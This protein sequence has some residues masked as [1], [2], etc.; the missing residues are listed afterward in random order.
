ML[1]SNNGRDGLELLRHNTV[2]VI[3]MDLQMPVMGGLPTLEELRKEFPNIPVIILTAFGEVKTAIE[4]M[5]L[6]AYDYLS[7]PMEKDVLIATVHRALENRELRR[8]IELW[9]SRAQKLSEGPLAE[10]KNPSMQ[11]VLEQVRLVSQTDYTVLLTGETGVG[12]DVMAHALHAQS[13]RAGKIF[14]PVDCGAIPE[15]LAESELFGYEKGAFTGADRRKEGLFELADGG[16]IF[17]DELSNLSEGTQA[18]ILRVLQERKIMRVGGK[19]FNDIDVRVIVATNMDLED[20]IKNGRFRED[21]FYRLNEFAITIPPLRD[22]LE[23]FESLADMFM[24]KTAMELGKKVALSSSAIDLMKNHSWPGNVRELRNVLRSA[25]LQCDDEI[26]P[27][28]VERLMRTR[29]PGEEPSGGEV[30]ASVNHIMH[31][32]TS[33]KNLVRDFERKI[34]AEVVRRSDGDNKRA[35]QLLGL[36]YTT[37]LE[38]LR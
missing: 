29:R 1:E 32:Q 27:E 21:L 28:H 2:D 31:G 4:A 5:R 37:L 36:H 8:E 38:K 25:M 16:T 15:N 7:K 6:G 20:E 26:K 33:L 34:S 30:E 11:K 19:E 12:K 23:D 17:L 22:R 35:A 18:K 24:A 9:R 13:K 3:F 14:I 10:S